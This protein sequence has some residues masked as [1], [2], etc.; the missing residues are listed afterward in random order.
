MLS[1]TVHLLLDLP[2]LN[3]CKQHKIRNLIIGSN[4]I[5]NQ[6]MSDIFNLIKHFFNE[7][8]LD[9][10]LIGCICPDDAAREHR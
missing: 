2:T 1:F 10:S 8:D 9:L 5:L 7:H 4:N 6:H 3:N